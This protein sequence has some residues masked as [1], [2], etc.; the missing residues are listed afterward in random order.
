MLCKSYMYRN[1]SLG[2]IQ[3]YYYFN[4]G[5]LRPSPPYASTLVVFI[6]IN[7]LCS[8]KIDKAY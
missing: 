4:F 6:M 7:K 2:V 3:K 8:Y 5:I 1:A